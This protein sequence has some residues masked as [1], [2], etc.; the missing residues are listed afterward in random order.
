MGNY[1]YP[2]ITHASLADFLPNF[3]RFLV[4]NHTSYSGPGWTIVEAYDSAHSA[5]Q[6]PSDASNI[7]SFTTVIS[8]K[9]SS[10]AT[11]DWIV[12]ESTNSNNS[13][14]FQLYLEYDTTTR[15]NIYMLPFENFSTGGSAVS[16]PL[17][18]T[19]SIGAGSGT[20]VQFFGYT[21]IARY[22]CV[23]TEGNIALIAERNSTTDC[24]YIYVG[25][26]DL[27]RTGT[28]V[29]PQD[30]RAYVINDTPSVVAYNTT[31]IFNRIS[32]IDNST[33]LVAG[34]ELNY[35]PNTSAWTLDANGVLPLRNVY[36]ILPILLGFR[37]T[38]HEH[39]AGY[40]RNVYTT[41]STCGIAGQFT[42]KNYIFRND[43]LLADVPIVLKW[44]GET[45][46]P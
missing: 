12:L 15:V 23:A 14:H 30:T 41:W 42:S 5:R 3:V 17:F 8:W 36:P 9:S 1:F 10:L 32:P 16:P 43:T 37:D 25:E 7:D 18:P 38:N 45:T 34:V 40:L 35:S 39:I 29:S 11:S 24:N 4:N 46:Y 27:P 31:D 26:V 6:V 20:F 19:N 2:N 21:A 22:L 44:D 13:N 33:H 28:G